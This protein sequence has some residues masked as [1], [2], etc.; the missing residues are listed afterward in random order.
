MDQFLKI[1]NSEY[2]SIEHVR[3][4]YNVVQAQN[5]QFKY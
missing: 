1:S 5:H 3:L 2:V 4:K